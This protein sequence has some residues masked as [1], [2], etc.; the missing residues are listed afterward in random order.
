M[1]SFLHFFS[2]LPSLKQL[3][4]KRYV[5]DF[6]LGRLVP[7]VDNI[8]LDVHISPQVHNTIK[9]AVSLLMIKH[10]RTEN[11]FEDYR[12]ERCE[13]EKRTL[14]HVC[15]NVLLEGINRAKSESEVQIDFLGQAS[16][17]KMF[18]EEIK[19]KYEELVAK[20]EDLIR[21]Y[22]LSHKHESF[23]SFKIKEKLSEIKQNQKRI[24]LHVGEELFQVL[25]GC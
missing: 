20:F 5:I 15:M 10:S 25:T 6:S 3:S 22:E 8:H 23:E 16:L 12:R 13:D 9:R 19:N 17:A 11:L 24:L 7:G 1:L 4:L 18:L 14:R 2:K 21:T